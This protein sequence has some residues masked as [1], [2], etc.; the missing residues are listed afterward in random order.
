MAESEW[1]HAN[2]GQYVLA[3]THRSVVMYYP[4]NPQLRGHN[5]YPQFPN[6]DWKVELLANKPPFTMALGYPSSTPV[7]SETH[8]FMRRLL[9]SQARTTK[10]L[11]N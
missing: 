10:R 5:S 8:G 9:G 1:P 6:I 11:S 4:P 7:H 3:S 2:C